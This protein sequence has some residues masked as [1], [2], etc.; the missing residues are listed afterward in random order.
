MEPGK[1]KGQE[2]EQEQ[3]QEQDR[4]GNTGQ[5]RHQG[6]GILK[7]GKG[8][9]KEGKDNHFRRMFQAWMEPEVVVLLIAF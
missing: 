9:L 4:T 5:S 8:I 3:E 1:Q 6:Q 2:Q 7:E